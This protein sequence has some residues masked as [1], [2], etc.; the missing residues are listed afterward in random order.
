MTVSV[1]VL[2]ALGVRADG[3]KV[4]LDVETL[5]SE[6]TTAWSGFVESLLARGLHRPQLCVLDGTPGLRAAVGTSW[7]GLAVQ[8]CVVHN[9]RNLERHAPQHARE[10]LAADYHR[11]VEAESGPLARQASHACVAKGEKRLP[12]VAASLR[13]AGEELLT[14]YRLPPSQWK[15]VR[16]TNA[17]ERLNEEFRRRVKTQGALPTAQTAELL[18]YGLLLTGQIRRRLIDGGRQSSAISNALGTSAAA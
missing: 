6:S 18:F 14:F 3:Q 15:C 16:S 9:L 17:I 4:V 8:R 7:P 12:K 13:E 11:I 10:E 5:P 2:V 1:P